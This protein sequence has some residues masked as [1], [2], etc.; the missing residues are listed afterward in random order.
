MLRVAEGAVWDLAFAHFHQA[1]PGHSRL[2][3]PMQVPRDRAHGQCHS[4][5]ETQSSTRHRLLHGTPTPSAGGGDEPNSLSCIPR[6]PTFRQKRGS[7]IA[8]GT[9]SASQS[10]LWHQVRAVTPAILYIHTRGSLCLL[11][12]LFIQCHTWKQHKSIAR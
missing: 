8:A 1:T 12:C 2:D 3:T 10:Y 4:C 7:L 5:D 11:P 6:I 9:S